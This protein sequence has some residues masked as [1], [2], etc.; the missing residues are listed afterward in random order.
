MQTGTWRAPVR[1]TARPAAQSFLRSISRPMMKSSRM[2]PI[3]ATVWMESR[4]GTRFRKTGP[5]IT[6][7]T[8]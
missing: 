4:L 6:P 8:R 5:M 3:S 1:I 2:R 7:V